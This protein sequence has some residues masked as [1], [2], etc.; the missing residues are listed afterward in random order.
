MLAERHDGTIDLLFTDVI[1]PNMNGCELATRL[2]AMRP[3]VKVL[4]ASGYA[5]DVIAR[6][7]ALDASESFI[8]K[9]Y[10]P[11]VLAARVREILD[12]APDQK[13]V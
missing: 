10:P 5:E 12:Q 2:T 9:P 1:M 8:A 7:G 13:G 3:G 11:A 4:Y 6:H